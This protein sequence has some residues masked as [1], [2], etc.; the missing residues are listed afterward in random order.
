MPGR[1]GIGEVGHL[2]YNMNGKGFN[3]VRNLNV[4]NDEQLCVCPI[5]QC[6]S[7]LIFSGGIFSSLKSLGKVLFF[8]NYNQEND[9]NGTE[10][11]VT[12]LIGDCHNLITYYI[13]NETLITYCVQIA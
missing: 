2:L 5:F 9:L 4:L 12:R 8:L 11:T 6:Y 10:N 13:K 7:N 1:E 3:A